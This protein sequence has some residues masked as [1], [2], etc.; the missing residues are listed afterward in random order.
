[1]GEAIYQPGTITAAVAAAAAGGVMI[2]GKDLVSE[3]SESRRLI[4]DKSFKL[5]HSLMNYAL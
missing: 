5:A 4:S 1:M 3:F 2:H